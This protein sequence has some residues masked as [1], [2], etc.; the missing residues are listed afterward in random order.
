[1]VPPDRR[2]KEKEETRE[3]I[4]D[5][6]REL[7]ARDGFHAVTMRRLAQ[8]IGYTP[9]AIYFHFA[10]KET[11]FREL[12]EADFLR[13]ATAFQ[14]IARVKDPVERLQKLGMTYVDFAI[15]HPHHY[16]LMFMS[17]I[18]DEAKA[19]A[20]LRKGDPTQDAYAFL[21]HTVQAVIATGRVRPEMRDPH[22][23][24]QACWAVVHGVVSLHISHNAG[25]RPDPFVDWRPA[26]RTAALAMDAL[27]HGMLLPGEDA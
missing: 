18:P 21:L 9:T 23:M 14:R 16:K 5:A 7:F 19:D 17:E 4:L 24:A 6:A 11:L 22:I 20:G 3:R 2:A 25:D 26:R 27:M 1:M 12:C 13:L 8:R 15:E 10:D